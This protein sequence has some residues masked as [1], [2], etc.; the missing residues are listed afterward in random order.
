MRLAAHGAGQGQA[1]ELDDE[2][3]DSDGFFLSQRGPSAAHTRSLSDNS[4]LLLLYR[5]SPLT[6][7]HPL[8]PSPPFSSL[9]LYC[10]IALPSHCEPHLSRPAIQALHTCPFTLPFPSSLPAGP[11]RRS[12][13]AQIGITQTLLT[14]HLHSL[15]VR[16]Q[17]GIVTDRLILSSR[18]VTAVVHTVHKLTY[19]D[20]SRVYGLT[21]HST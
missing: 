14:F 9:S 4:H 3:S 19:I 10:S 8:S 7:I 13:L 6:S 20:H 12:L 18:Y 11:P 16:V 1:P 15:L 5:F 17:A 2:P 21:D